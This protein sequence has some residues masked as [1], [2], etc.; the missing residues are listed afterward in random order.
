ML[1]GAVPVAVGVFITMPFEPSVALLVEPL[2]C[3]PDESMDSGRYD[4]FDAE[5]NVTEIEFEFLCEGEEGELRDVETAILIILIG[6]LLLGIGALGLAG[7]AAQGFQEAR[8][9]R[10]PPSTKA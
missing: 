9:N 4:E 10:K 3:E 1:M 5:D 8:R 6:S 7:G 2:V